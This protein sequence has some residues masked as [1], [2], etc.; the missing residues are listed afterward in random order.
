VKLP[1]VSNVL[2]ANHCVFLDKALWDS[3]ETLLVKI[4]A[5][6]LA[7]SQVTTTPNNVKA[8]F[9]RQR[10]QQQSRRSSRPAARI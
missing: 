6:A 9:N 3:M 2:C 8:E 5:T 1:R 7:L 4:F 10:D